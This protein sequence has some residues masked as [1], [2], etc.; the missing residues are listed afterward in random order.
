MVPSGEEWVKPSQMLQPRQR[1]IAEQV[2]LVRL[3]YHH[4]PD[5]AQRTIILKPPQQNALGDKRIRLASLAIRI[6]TRSSQ[7]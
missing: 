1:H 6:K 5:S 4:G 3:I 2:P 7:I